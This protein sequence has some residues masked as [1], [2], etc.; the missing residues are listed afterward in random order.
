MNLTQT[1]PSAW[2]DLEAALRQRHPVQVGYHGRSRIVCPH[3]LGWKNQRA[4]LLG[5]QIGGHTSSGTLDPDPHKR[6]R[7]MYIDEIDHV[8]ADT[9]APWQTTGNYNPNRPF[10]AID[11]VIL[12]V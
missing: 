7:C 12:A 5:Y 4:M 10:P 9:T 8:E 3:A 2:A 1:L 6:W 11:R